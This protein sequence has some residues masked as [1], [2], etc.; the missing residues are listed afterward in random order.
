MLPVSNDTFYMKKLKCIV[1]LL[2]FLNLIAC[3][4]EGHI[5]Q[6]KKGFYIKAHTGNWKHVGDF[7]YLPVLTTLINNSVDTIRYLSFSCSWYM[8]YTTNNIHLSLYSPGCNRNVPE[9]MT[10]FP[11]TSEQERTVLFQTK[12]DTINLKGI[13]FRVG[14]NYVSFS[15]YNQLDNEV[16]KLF[17]HSNLIWS[18]TLVIK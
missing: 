12:D 5:T 4:S 1:V 6:Q 14:F 17:K 8:S 13:I 10:I 15:S 11:N 16:K 7:N 9:V 18:D 3:K 2:F